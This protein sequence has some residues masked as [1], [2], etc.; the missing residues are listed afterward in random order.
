MLRHLRRLFGP[1]PTPGPELA[2][3]AEAYTGLDFRACLRRPVEQARFVALDLET[4]GFEAYGSDAVVSLAMLELEGTRPTG[5]TL[6]HLV[7]PGRPIP[8]ESTAI[9]GIDDAMVAGAPHLGALLPEILEFVGDA[10][11]VGHHLAFDLRFLNR[12]LRE[13]GGP[14]LRNPLIDTMLLFLG[15]TGRLGHYTLEEVAAYCHVQVEG[16]HSAL[17]DARA[18]A[19]IFA[20]LAPRLC[21]PPCTVAGLISSQGESP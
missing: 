2:R 16:R 7:D 3:A 9:H 8:P 14:R 11:L 6:R 5:R 15:H 13:A 4:T 17:G 10:A 1:R 21:R 20:V 12:A 18:A 19:D